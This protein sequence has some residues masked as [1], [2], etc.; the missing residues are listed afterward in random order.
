MQQ[1]SPL[2]PQSDTPGASPWQLG[3][4]GTV[5]ESP[6][7]VE[8]L[9]ALVDPLALADPLAVPD[10]VEPPDPLG[11]P[12]AEPDVA[13]LPLPPDM[14]PSELPAS[15][16]PAAVIDPVD[17]ASVAVP[18]DSPPWLTW[19]PHPTTKTAKSSV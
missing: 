16:A 9:A 13:S 17:P 10:P 14:A 7:G 12:D 8:R 4:M 15:S 18:G 6:P 1:L 19:P 5:P 11:V 2:A 3:G